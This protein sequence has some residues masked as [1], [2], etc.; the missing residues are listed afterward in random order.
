MT[1]GFLADR[2]HSQPLSNFAWVLQGKMGL[3]NFCKA[4]K[5]LRKFSQGRYGVAKFSHTLRNALFFHLL[6]NS[7]AIDHKKFN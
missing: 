5:G 2:W 1:F 4:N 3:R 6:W 7:L